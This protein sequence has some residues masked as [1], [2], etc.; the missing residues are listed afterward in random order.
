MSSALNYF[1]LEPIRHRHLGLLKFRVAQVLHERT[2]GRFDEWYTKRSRQKRP[3]RNLGT[4]EF[5]TS[6]EI[7][8]AV[9]ELTRDGCSI[10]PRRLDDQDISEIAAFA[11]STPAWG[12]HP[13]ERIMLTPDALPRNT[14]RHTWDMDAVIRIPAVQRL[15]CDPTLHQIA[16]DYIGAEPVLANV[17]LSI[18]APA[19]KKFD[20]HMYHYDNDGPRFLKYFVYITDVEPDTGAHCFIKGSHGHIKPEAFRISKLHDDEKELL[21]FYGS[22]KE[23]VFS[24]PKGTIIAED[25][26]GFHRGSTVQRKHR[27][28]MTLQYALLD[29]PTTDELEGR[30]K[31]VIVQGLPA[32][33]RPIVSKFFHPG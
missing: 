32:P 33:V 15:I 8:D 31:P 10:L 1:L 2:N 4:P 6:A 24:A 27:I 21:E 23:I 13:S 20:A 18:D 5:L 28:L 25:T 16:Q 26:A 30:I 17:T 19:D 29:I 11:F 12:T 7:S 22:D 14:A 3:P 9:S